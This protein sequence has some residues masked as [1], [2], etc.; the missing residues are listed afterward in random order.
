MLSKES[1]KEATRKFKEKIVLAG[2]Y[3]VRCTAT[4]HV[5]VGASR[6]LDATKNGLWSGLFTGL[7]REKT[8]Q[9]EWAAHG[10]TAFQYEVL[11][12]LGEDVDPL[13]MWDLLKEKKKKWVAEL[14]AEPLL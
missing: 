10:E 14:G 3:A 13:N 8:L 2:A 7:H 9:E 4:G 1:R 12:S 11:E 5:W 6:N